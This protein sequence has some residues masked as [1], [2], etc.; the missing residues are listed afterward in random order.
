ML[1][2][3]QNQRWLSFHTTDNAFTSTGAISYSVGPGGNFN[4]TT[5]PN[6]L[7]AAFFRQTLNSTPNQVDY[8][9]QILEAREDYD[10][11]A[12]KKSAVLAYVYFL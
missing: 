5:R 3:W 11:M 10:L 4:I 12:L 8:P 1:G 6:R 7:E 9:L 2:Q